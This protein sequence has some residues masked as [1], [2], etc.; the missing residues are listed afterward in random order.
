ML[1]Y[2]ISYFEL[3]GVIFNRAGC[4]IFRYCLYWEYTLWVDARCGN[5][6]FN[7]IG[8]TAFEKY[9]DKILKWPILVLKTK[10]VLSCISDHNFKHYTS[11]DSNYN[12]SNSN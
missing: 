6:S 5:C 4:D 7:V 11:H 12:V 8:K 10:T 1:G 3:L 2:A 9:G